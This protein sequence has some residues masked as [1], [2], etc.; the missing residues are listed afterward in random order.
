MQPV[1]PLKASLIGLLAF[2]IFFITFF[3]GMGNIIIVA[4]A[5]TL[6]VNL[7]LSA[8]MALGNLKQGLLTA[9]AYSAPVAVFSALSVGDLVLKGNS[10][11][12]LFWL[13]ATGIVFSAGVLGVLLVCLYRLFKPKS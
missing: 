13:S 6:L 3:N 1:Q 8:F 4:A 5:I 2:G 9:T 10:A 11:P 12:F 7:L